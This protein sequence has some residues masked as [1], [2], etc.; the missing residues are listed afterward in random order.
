MIYVAAIHFKKILPMTN[1]VTSIAQMIN[2]QPIVLP[3]II[4]YS[5][6]VKGCVNVIYITFLYSRYKNV[7]CALCNGISNIGKKDC[8]IA[9]DPRTLPPDFTM[10]ISLNAKKSHQTVLQHLCPL[11]HIFIPITVSIRT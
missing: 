6:T 5:L 10:L 11:R 2:P 9:Q 1:P 8:I 4:V 3:T 7:F